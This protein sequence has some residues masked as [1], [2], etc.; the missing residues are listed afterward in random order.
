MHCVPLCIIIY[1][2]MMIL[3]PKTT[4]LLII[5]PICNCFLKVKDRTVIATTDAEREVTSP[6]G[7]QDAINKTVARFQKARSFVR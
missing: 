6:S 5:Y 2:D 7:L 3:L 4:F 1:V